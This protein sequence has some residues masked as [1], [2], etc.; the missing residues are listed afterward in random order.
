[1]ARRSSCANA[2]GGYV[3]V[4]LVI[5]TYRAVIQ[6]KASNAASLDPRVFRLSVEHRIANYNH[7]VDS[8]FLKQPTALDW[9]CSL[10]PSHSIPLPPRPSH[11]AFSSI[12]CGSNKLIHCHFSFHLACFIYRHDLQVWSCCYKWHDFSVKWLNNNIPLSLYSDFIYPLGQPHILALCI[13]A[14]TN[15]FTCSTQSRDPWVNSRS[16]LNI[17]E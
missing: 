4:G 1:M 5:S 7:D 9:S 6:T 17:S 13:V 3:W 11:S 16:I 10:L 15:L 14:A 8:T 12:E 2:R